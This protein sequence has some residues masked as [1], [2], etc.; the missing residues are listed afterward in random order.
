MTVKKVWVISVILGLLILL[1]FCGYLVF[2]PRVK[3]TKNITA[4]KIYIQS[5]KTSFSPN[6]QMTAKVIVDGD[7][8][9]F[10]SFKAN[11]VLNNLSV[12]GDLSLGKDVTNWQTQPNSSS[13][14]FFGGVQGKTNKITVYTLTLKTNTAGPASIVVTDGAIYQVQ[15]DN[16]TVSDILASQTGANYTVSSLPSFLVP[17]THII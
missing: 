12:V 2:K 3:S 15:S 10:T 13:L 6:E 14:D 11:I 4:P 17:K 7:G 9:T 16:M 1:G 8:Q 5:S